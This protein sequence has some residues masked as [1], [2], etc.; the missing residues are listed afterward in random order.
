[1]PS[2][3]ERRISF[4]VETKEIKEVL[5]AYAKNHGLKTVSNL[6]HVA[7]YQYVRKYNIKI[8]DLSVNNDSTPNDT[9]I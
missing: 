6:A 5:G 7:L 1:M 3:S 2:N 4:V 8:N 9:N